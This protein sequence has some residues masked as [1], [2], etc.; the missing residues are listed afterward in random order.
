MAYIEP[1]QDQWMAL[2]QAA[3]EYKRHELWKFMTDNQVFGV[4]DPHRGKT[5]FCTVIGNAGQ[6]YGLVVYLGLEGL[7]VLCEMYR[8]G[9]DIMQDP[10]FMYQQDTFVMSFG[11]REELLPWDLKTIKKLG[12]KY[13][14]L[15]AWPSFARHLPGY[16]PWRLTADEAGFMTEILQQ[17]A[18]VGERYLQDPDCLPPMQSNWYLIRIKG[19][20]GWQDQLTECLPQKPEGNRASDIPV[21]QRAIEDILAMNLKR[22]GEWEVDCFY[23]PV[24]IHESETE[25]PYFAYMLAVMDCRNGMAL[26]METAAPGNYAEPF[27]KKV[28]ATMRNVRTV[29]QKIYYQRDEIFSLFSSVAEKLGIRLSRVKQLNMVSDFRQ[30]LDKYFS[31][32]RGKDR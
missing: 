24:Y 28:L 3:E 30:G 4:K 10:D 7:H 31:K 20:D 29:P 8:R 22:Q 17:A 27:M 26:S 32:N 11:G 16:Y 5:G 1:T 18:I 9:D 14:G 6:M 2:Y 13:R 23:G 21:A 12:L 15:N 25:R 19:S